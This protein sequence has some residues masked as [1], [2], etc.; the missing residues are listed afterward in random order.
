MCSAAASGMC[1]RRGVRIGGG[2]GRLAGMERA[3]GAAQA[4]RAAQHGATDATD[5]PSRHSFDRVLGVNASGRR[6]EGG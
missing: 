4:Q 5:I 1:V 6:M 2:G 3:E